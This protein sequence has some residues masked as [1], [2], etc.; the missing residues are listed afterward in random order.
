MDN[1]HLMVKKDNNKRERKNFSLTNLSLNGRW[2]DV[3]KGIQEKGEKKKSL[4]HNEL[5]TSQNMER[6]VEE[7]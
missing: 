6:T 2:E 5:S 7:E 1:S 4:S 3:R